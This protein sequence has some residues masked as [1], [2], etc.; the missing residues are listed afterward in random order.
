MIIHLTQGVSQNEDSPSD[1]SVNFL[2]CYIKSTLVCLMHWM[3][4]FM[5]DFKLQLETNIW[6]N[7]FTESQIFQ[8]IAYCILEYLTSYSLCNAIPNLNRKIFKD[9]TSGSPELATP[10]SYTSQELQS[11]A[12]LLTAY[13]SCVL[14]SL[15]LE[16]KVAL[17]Q[18]KARR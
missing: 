15:R 17:G 3:A 12:R 18:E 4:L 1:I 16:A 13:S 11:R 9:K 5:H 2:F 7:S 6:K 10:G 14:W 8:R